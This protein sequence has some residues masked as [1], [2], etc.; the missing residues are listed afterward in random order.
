MRAL[1]LSIVVLVAG[2]GGGSNGSQ[3]QC[4]QSIVLLSWTIKGQAATADQGCR[5]VASLAVELRSECN[6][7][8]IEPIPCINGPRWQYN[9]LP[10]GP[11]YVILD[12]LDSHNQI[13]AE[14]TATVTLGADVP[15][16]PTPI[17]LE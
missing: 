14:G 1:G 10:G 2:C 5:G 4:P 12:A 9:E 15:A 17:D 13:L 11:N 3:S 16:T 8:S 7:V 6:D